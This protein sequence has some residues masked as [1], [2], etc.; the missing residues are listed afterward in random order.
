M[1]FAARCWSPVQAAL[2][3]DVGALQQLTD[4]ARLPMAQRSAAVALAA[5][6]LLP[7]SLGEVRQAGHQE[8]LRL[9]GAAAS[10]LL[11]GVARL[12]RCLQLRAQLGCAA[13]AAAEK[14][15]PWALK[16]LCGAAV[17]TCAGLPEG[18]RSAA[19]SRSWPA[20]L[21][22]PSSTGA[23]ASA[24]AA[25]LAPGPLPDAA[26]PLL[27]KLLAGALRSAESMRV[28]CP[29]TR[30]RTFRIL[31]PLPAGRL[32][33]LPAAQRWHRLPALL[34]V[35]AAAPLWRSGPLSQLPGRA[36]ALGWSLGVAASALSLALHGAATQVSPPHPLRPA[37]QGGGWDKLARHRP[38]LPNT[39]Q[40]LC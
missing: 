8:P 1:D 26:D 14:S 28:W 6:R 13:E 22:L 7:A 29:T 2:D 39:D 11:E 5:Q 40:P 18:A 23:E 37:A 3:D 32:T 35:L 30:D 25:T 19:A 20:L 33:T 12:A 38:E 36:E 10:A 27:T 31:C 16:A 9:D 24:D 4:A 17:P 34:A 15:V 21:G